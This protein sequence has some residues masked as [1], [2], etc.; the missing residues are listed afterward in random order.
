VVEHHPISSIQNRAPIDFDIPGS[1]KQY[2]DTSNIQ[3]HVRA[4]IV[5]AA[6]NINNDA[7]VAPVN[8]LLRSMFSQVDILLNSMLIC[9]STNT[10]PYRTMQEMMLSYGG[11]AKTSQLTCEMYNKDTPG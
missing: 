4:K 2:I 7:A 10:Y 5:R 11:D 3:L 9:S 8:L 1:G 6:G